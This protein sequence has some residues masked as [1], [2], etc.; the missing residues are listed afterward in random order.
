MIQPAR[1]LVFDCMQK[2]RDIVHIYHY[3]YI[4][5]YIYTVHILSI[6]IIYIYI[7]TTIMDIVTLHYPLI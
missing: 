1:K 7:I 6:I 2:R 5:I 4:Y 3:L